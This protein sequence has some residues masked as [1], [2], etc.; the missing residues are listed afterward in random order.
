M[1]YSIDVQGGGKAMEY[2]RKQDTVT[3]KLSGE[4]DHCSAQGIRRELDQLL[5]EPGV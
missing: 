2:T 3:V 1:N 4:L 5:E